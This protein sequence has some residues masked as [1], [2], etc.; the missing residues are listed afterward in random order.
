M[1]YDLAINDGTIVDGTG[2]PR[3]RG[4]LG[5]LDGRIAAISNDP[6]EGRERF[7]ARGLIVAPGFVDVHSHGDLL[8][9]L[10]EDYR[11]SRLKQGITLELTGQ[12]GIGPIPYDPRTMEA[13]KAYV[14]PV[15]G[16]VGGEWNFQDLDSLS[17]VMEGRMPHHIAYLVGLGALRSHICGLDPRALTPQEIDELAR[18]Y[19]EQLD[20]GALGLSL[21]LSYLPGVYARP[22]ELHRLAAVTAK[23]GALLMAHIR[24]H[25]RD[26]LEAMEEYVDL[27]RRTGC[28][29]H[30]SHCRS[31][32]N[33]DFG[34]SA[35][36]T[37]ALVE[38]I[39]EEGIDLTLDQHPYTAGS[40]F[41][42]QLL[43]PQYRDHTRYGDEAL[44]EEIEGKISDKA[45]ALPGWDNF[46]L[47]V[48]FDNI[49]L[50]NDGATIGELAGQ[51]GVS[52]FRALIDVLIREEGN[53]TMV[54][55][56]MFS[57]EDTSQLLHDPKTYIGSDGLPNGR[58]HPRLYG[59]FPK[60][61][62]TYVREQGALSLEEAIRRMTGADLLGFGDRGEIREGK[63]ADLTL[64]DELEIGHEESYSGP[65]E[66]PSG[67]R[68]VF[69]EGRL[70]YD[71]KNVLA[72]KG[73][74]L[75][76]RSG[77]AA[78]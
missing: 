32:K 8:P 50:P 28:R 59:A 43:P 19:E 36:E 62:A 9:L 51:W 72:L 34:V 39:R 33:R 3:C 65:N 46:S 40:T 70:A 64:F 71:G 4:N 41:L 68:A 20:Q 10:P 49:Y 11:F 31:F 45:Y 15:I 74:V 12:C 2:A 17:A 76:G 47:M 26:M 42:N 6:L 77:H 73:R 66:D 24:S 23:R 30:I 56:E 75:K 78:E 67:I 52:P 7:D 38:R 63:V 60:V 5:I 55:R 27:S 29:I 54:V 69:L 48:G 14:E 16:T 13:Y 58:P 25:G 1:I 44:L 18:L 22:E 57:L 61:I 53:A 21:G 35:G 37:L